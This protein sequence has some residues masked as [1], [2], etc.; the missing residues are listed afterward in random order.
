MVKFKTLF[1]VAALV[2]V[3]M[4]SLACVPPQQSASPEV[5]QEESR[6]VAEE[7]VRNSPTFAFDGMEDTLELVETL[8]PDIEHAWGF[9]F[10]FDCRHGGYGD[11]TGKMVTQAITPHEATV[12]VERGEVKTA[13]LDGKWDMINQKMLD[14]Q[15]STE[16]EGTSEAPAVSV[17][18]SYNNEQVELNVGELLEVTLESNASTGFQWQLAEITDPD[19]VEKKTDEYVEPE[20]DEQVV[21]APGKEIWTFKALDEGT[22]NIS[23]KYCRPWEEDADPAKTFVLTVVVK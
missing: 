16:S 5:T 17:N 7:F 4:L 11:R 10:H 8:Y 13:V 2:L 1:G 21:G 20:G 19:V 18:A 6:E 14:E 12:N 9:V 23:M 15:G 3:V 22:A